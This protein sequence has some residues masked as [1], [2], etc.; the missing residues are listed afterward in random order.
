[1]PGA[2]FALQANKKNATAHMCQ[3]ACQ[4]PR[5]LDATAGRVT[6]GVSQAAHQILSVH[7]SNMESSVQNSNTSS[8]VTMGLCALRITGIAMFQWR[9]CLNC[10]STH[11]RPSRRMPFLK[12]K[13]DCIELELHKYPRRTVRQR[14][15]LSHQSLSIQTGLF[16][17]C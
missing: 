14:S 7:N 5:K 8:L 17:L 9:E 12:P 3:C 11:T 16:H 4:W 13:A 2:G 6:A 15:I 10:S 1:M